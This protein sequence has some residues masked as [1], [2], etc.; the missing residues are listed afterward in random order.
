MILISLL[1]YTGAYLNDLCTGNQFQDP[2]P[3][4][5]A[6]NTQNL[7]FELLI[8]FPCFCG[9]CFFVY[10]I[11]KMIFKTGSQ[12]ISEIK[13]EILGRFLYSLMIFSI[14][15]VPPGY[16]GYLTITRNQNDHDFLLSLKLTSLCLCSQG[17]FFLFGYL[18]N[19]SLVDI[20]FCSCSI[21][22]F[23]SRDQINN[24]TKYHS[25]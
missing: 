8:V 20:C 21:P 10:F 24:K 5:I 12:K 17:F 3:S 22:L 23:R 7:Q 19:L 14:G 13:N 11:I 25:W 1:W 4:P 15:I 2:L 9:Y 6:Y 18:L 16:I